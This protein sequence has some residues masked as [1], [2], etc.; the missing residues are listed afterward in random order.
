MDNCRRPEMTGAALI[1]NQSIR[2]F[3]PGNQ[4]LM[5]WWMRNKLIVM[6]PM[7]SPIIR[8]K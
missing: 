6:Q 4:C 3:L 7:R 2:F 5:L 1:S 8:Y